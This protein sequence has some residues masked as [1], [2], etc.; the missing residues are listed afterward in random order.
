VP[1]R[2]R[3]FQLDVC[4]TLLISTFYRG[5]LQ[6]FINRLATK[7]TVTATLRGVLNGLFRARANIPKEFHSPKWDTIFKSFP[8]YEP[9]LI[10]VRF[11]L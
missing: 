10:P 9:S 3:E 7:P 6:E 2:F 8:G 4:S 1:A 11:Y 5:N